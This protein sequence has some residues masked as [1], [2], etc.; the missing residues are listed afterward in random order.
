M[1]L[2]G[3][4]A[5]YASGRHAGLG[6]SHRCTNHIL[7]SGTGSGEPGKWHVSFNRELESSKSLASA[8]QWE[9]GRTT[10][11]QSARPVHCQ[12]SQRRR[13]ASGSLGQ[14]SRYSYQITCECSS[15]RFIFLTLTV[16]RRLEQTGSTLLCGLSQEFHQ[17]DGLTTLKLLSPLY[18]TL[19]EVHFK[20]QTQQPI[21]ASCPPAP[22]P[23][24]H[25]PLLPL[26]LSGP[27][28]RTLQ[29]RLLQLARRSSR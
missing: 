13:L 23:S 14:W 3:S 7:C 10:N 8:P 1:G 11:R 18:L 12:W 28:D 2:C 17:L 16:Q 27:P 20:V 9:T 25:Y 24:C 6:W 19:L 26:L 22:S 4:K 5:Y 21:S 15:F 29:K